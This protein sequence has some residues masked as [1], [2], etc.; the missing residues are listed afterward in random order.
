MTSADTLAWYNTNAPALMKTYEQLRAESIH[1]WLID[2]L[3]GAG[4]AALDI[5]SGLSTRRISLNPS[6]RGPCA[7]E[8]AQPRAVRR[9]VLVE[10]FTSLTGRP[11]VVPHPRAELRGMQRVT[12]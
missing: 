4:A 1:G 11:P 10:E 3:P 12:E 5:G 6:W 7:S 9:W 8:N 2:L